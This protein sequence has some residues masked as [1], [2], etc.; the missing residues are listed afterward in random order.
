MPWLYPKGVS[1]GDFTQAPRTSLIVAVVELPSHASARIDRLDQS[2]N[3]CT[4]PDRRVHPLD[5]SVGPRVVGRGQPIFDR[6]ARADQTKAQ[7][8]ERYAV[9]LSSWLFSEMNRSASSA[10]MHPMP[11]DVTACRYL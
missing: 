6:V 1:T 3:A 10:A 5:L 4:V 8:A 2:L 9:A 7:L 11:A